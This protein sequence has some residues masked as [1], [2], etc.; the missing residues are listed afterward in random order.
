ME[1]DWV[2]MLRLNTWEKETNLASRHHIEQ[3]ESIPDPAVTTNT[4]G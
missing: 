4:D 1:E 2:G 3:P